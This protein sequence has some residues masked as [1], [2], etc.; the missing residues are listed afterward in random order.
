MGSIAGEVVVAADCLAAEGVGAT[1]AVASSIRPAPVE[2][3]Q[4]LLQQFGT[5][6]TV[7]A[8]Y[9]NGGLGSLVSELAAE[10]G[11]GCR[12]VRCAVRELPGGVSGSREFLYR[13]HGLDAA[14]LCQAALR[15][16]RGTA[17]PS[18][19]AA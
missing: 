10:R 7:E 15:C 9:E 18:G 17:P 11:L 16:L 8:H 13:R 5:V 3:L 19:G 12:L 4:G 2:D 1:V 6:L 14:S